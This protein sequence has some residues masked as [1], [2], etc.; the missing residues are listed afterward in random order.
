MSLSVVVYPLKQR[1][2]VLPIRDMGA[3]P[4]FKA[5]LSLHDTR[6]GPRASRFIVTKNGKEEIRQPSE[7][8][9]LLRLA[10][11][12][13]IATGGD[14]EKEERFLEFLSAYQ[15]DYRR[16]SLCRPCLLN[17]RVMF[18]GRGSIKYRGEHICWDCAWDELKRE[19]RFKGEMSREALDRLERL[20]RRT[21]D[22]DRVIGFLSPK[23][24]DED[25]TRYD[26]IPASK[27]G[28]TARFDELPLH[29][30][31]K[32]VFAGHS[33]RLLPVQDLS[34]KAGL[35]KGEDQ[36]I[37]SATATGKTLIGEM[38]G[39]QNIIDGRGKMLFLVP[40]VAL[41]NQKHSQFSRKYHDLGFNSSI[42]V[43]ASRIYK[44]GD[45]TDYGADIIVGTYEGL[46]HLIRTGKHDRLGKI[47]TV[48]IDEVHMLEDEERGHRLDGLI[49]RL[50]E[51]APDAQFIYLSATVADPGWL[52]ERLRAKL[53]EYEERPIPIERH[54][55]FARGPEK[56]RLITRLSQSEYNQKSSKGYRGQTIVFTNSRR[57]CHNIADAIGRMAEPYHAGLPNHKRKVV[58]KK[59]AGGDIA[60]VVTTAALAAGVDF[61]A[62]QVI[63]ESLA[64]G[65]EWL[66]V[67]EFNQ[68]LGRAGRPDYH[69]KGKVVI[70]AEPERSYHG[71]QQETEDKVAMR[72][73]QGQMEHHGIRYPKG[74]Q[75]EQTLAN[76]AIKDTEEGLQEMSKK[77][78]GPVDVGSALESLSKHGLIRRGERIR[79]TR[80]GWVA[81]GHF[82]TPEQATRIRELVEA[83]EAPIDILVELEVFDKAY[84][85]SAGKISST[86]GVNVPSR[87]FHGAF[88]DILFE[89]DAL[90]RLDHALQEQLTEFASEFLACGCRDTPYCGCPEREF[91]K[92]I[93]ELRPMDPRGISRHLKDLYGVHVYGGDL[94]S[95]LDQAVRN[96]EAVEQTAR[97]LGKT[98]V[99]RA[100]QSLRGKVES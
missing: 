93:I 89:G 81:S 72:L 80:M 6:K 57:N 12:I 74:A 77:M 70:L 44:S 30:L 7:A 3:Q 65:V 18:V 75:E 85:T 39:A 43:G 23:K 41:A 29:P 73:L 20:L 86:L 53:I 68:M 83:G 88:L 13:L 35:F 36:L 92:R 87:V 40:L 98:E 50:K 63:F 84:L 26:T 90:A 32:K 62:S 27:T 22:L 1:I 51:I 19:A 34:V 71:S 79:P 28:E 24:L 100:A 5:T 78:L 64:M 56:V 16:V 2:H 33:P 38:A 55:F 52:A 69:D 66:S 58:E 4:V 21:N 45:R 17:G 60:V 91:S 11:D 14:Q 95:Y 97:I 76:L 61:P 8:V 37:V 96:L 94:L 47:G 42:R 48:V 10:D 15:L 31:L 25:L 54:L 99:K 9:D 67:Q 59:F 46:D 49:A 82:L